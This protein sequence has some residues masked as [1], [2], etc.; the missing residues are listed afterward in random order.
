[1]LSS[2]SELPLAIRFVRIMSSFEVERPQQMHPLR[3][4]NTGFGL[5][6]MSGL[7][8]EKQL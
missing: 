7:L 5:C 4:L 2:P 8:M 1:M 6:N 3:C